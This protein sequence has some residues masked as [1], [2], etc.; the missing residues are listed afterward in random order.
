[1]DLSIGNRKWEQSMNYLKRA[2][3]SMSRRPGKTVILLLL[4]FVL[5]NVIAGATSIRTA[6]LNTDANLRAQLPAITILD[7]DQAAMMAEHNRTGE[8]P[9]PAP[10][11]LETIREVGSLPYVRY[12]NYSV[13]SNTFSAELDRSVNPFYLDES[14]SWI[15]DSFQDW[16]AEQRENG[17]EY[18]SFNL[19][20]TSDPELVEIQHGLIELVEG[21][22]LTAEELNS[23][24][25]VAVVSRDF[26]QVNNLSVGDV[27]DLTNAFFDWTIASSWE[28]EQS[29]EYMVDSQP[30]SLTIVGL[31]DMSAS[32]GANGGEIWELNRQRNELENRFFVPNAIA[33]DSARFLIATQFEWSEA[34]NMG[35]FSDAEDFNVEDAIEHTAMFYLENPAYLQAFAEEAND[36]LPEFRMIT[37]LSNTF[38]DIAGSME[39]M[40]MIANI[41]L[42]VAVGATLVIL[43]LLITLFLRDRK[44]EIGIYLALGEKKGR[45]ASQILIEVMSTAIVAVTLSLFTGAIIS[46]GISQQ[47]VQNDLQQRQEDR[48]QTGSSWSQGEFELQMFSPGEMTMEDMLAAYDTSLDGTAVALFFGVAS[49]TILISTLAPMM[50]VMRLNPK[51]VMM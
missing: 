33:E 13:S 35:W 38:G 29:S 17:A 5:G 1:M 34:N 36:I 49:A 42:W 8:W 9:S 19:R 46:S 23:G 14:D 44:H 7:S 6:V 18:V 27:L 47:M 31:F 15:M 22:L 39:T 25:P 28:T 21:R 11:S 48:W 3:A 37:D 20:G 24:A 4:V 40:L 32:F 10:L 2:L 45:I 43:S 12:F 51:K 16:Q 41:V 50:Y 26:A 30:L